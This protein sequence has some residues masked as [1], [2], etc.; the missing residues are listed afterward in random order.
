VGFIVVFQ[1]GCLKNWCFLVGSTNHI[2]SE[3]NFGRSLE[4]LSQIS[5]LS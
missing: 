2:N 1:V 4:Y 5:K 3:N